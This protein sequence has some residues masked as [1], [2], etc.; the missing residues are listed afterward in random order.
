M[1]ITA[2][3]H[4]LHDEVKA[5]RKLHPVAEIHLAAIKKRIDHWAQGPGAN[6]YYCARDVLA[7]A[8]PGLT[9]SARSQIIYSAIPLLLIHVKAKGYKQYT[10][11]FGTSVWVMPL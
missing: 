2:S 11:S 7:S 3:S 8:N 10:P 1:T 9:L 4:D 6:L 5:A